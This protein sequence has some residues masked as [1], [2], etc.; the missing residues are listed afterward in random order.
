VAAPRAAQPVDFVLAKFD[1]EDFR[2]DVPV[3]VAPGVQRLVAPNASAMTGPGTNGYLLGDPPV[4]IVDPGPDDAAHVA[5]IRAF[6]PDL[7][8]IF[9]THTHRDHS[10]AAATLARETGARVVGRAPPPVDVHDQT[11][12]PDESPLHDQRY[13]VGGLTLRAI[14]TP[15]HA[16]NHVCWL[17][18]EHGL[19]FSGDH[20]LDG[21]T[22]VILPPDGDMAAYMDSLRRLKTYPLRAIAPGHG[23]VLPD[24][25]GVIDHVI[26][27]R[28]QREARVATALRELGPA[29]LGELVVRV[30]ADVSPSL[31]WLARRSLEAHLIKLANEGRCVR[32]GDRW[33]AAADPA[34]DPAVDPMADP[35]PADDDRRCASRGP[36]EG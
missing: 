19:L 24:P 20:V 30:Y 32:E 11:L 21:V 9:V 4:A 17:V 29:T 15:G 23:R 1:P 27:H 10:P 35:A 33:I 3:T 16:A 2:P 14:H 31:H 6:A 18:E 25:Q 12:Q 28:L 22:P 8:W 26:A 7:A 34:A 5:A 36:G 13:A